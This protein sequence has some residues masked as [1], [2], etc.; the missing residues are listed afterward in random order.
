MSDD[1]ECVSQARLEYRHGYAAVRVGAEILT[2]RS[3]DA[4]AAAG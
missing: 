4:P 2:L 1:F 3:E